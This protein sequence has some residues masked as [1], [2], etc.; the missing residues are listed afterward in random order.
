MTAPGILASGAGALFDWLLVIVSVD[1]TKGL[2]LFL[3]AFFLVRFFPSLPRTQA[4]LVW[5]I[6]IAAFVA[7]PLA[8]RLL[9][10]V[11][12]WHPGSPISR[13][14]AGPT[15]FSSGA[16][17]SAALG[18]PGVAPLNLMPLAVAGVWIAGTVFLLSRLG[19]S[20]LFLRRLVSRAVPFAPAIAPLRH[21][22]GR[23]GIRRT[24]SVMV[25]RACTVP[26]TCGW[27]RPRIFLPESSRLWSAQRLRAVL[28]HE[29]S[30]IRREDQLWNL[31][32]GLACALLWFIPPLWIACSLML[33]EA[34]KC[35]DQAVLDQGIHRTEYASA[36]VELSR[37][38]RA[39]FLAAGIEG[40]AGRRNMLKKRITDIL[41]WSRERAPVGLR[42]AG[43]AFFLLF[44]ILLLLLAV[45]VT[46][47][48]AEKLYGTWLNTSGHGLYKWTFH[49]DGTS[50]YTNS[51]GTI[52]D[53]GR[54]V[55]EKKWMDAEGYT[56]YMTKEKWSTGWYHEL[57]AQTCYA[58]AR[59]DPSGRYMETDQSTYGY[60]ESFFGPVGMGVHQIYT[61]Q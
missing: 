12:L 33:R 42:R 44:V 15:V 20:R 46:T 19:I 8:R 7:L 16:L 54:V 56:W 59:V 51:N 37:E 5:L 58:L 49:P 34:E 55:I 25:S 32:A 24:V 45:S 41:S 31:G 10:A 57:G 38:T 26:F 47:N 18:D 30:H 21:V 35:C 27:L 50:R 43:R 4:H 1:M 39:G 9:P 23:A 36:L 53:V 52:N 60:P 14:A 3:L 22:V 48:A 2:L 17:P 28:I 11:S 29:A 40:L 6:V 61:R 13:I